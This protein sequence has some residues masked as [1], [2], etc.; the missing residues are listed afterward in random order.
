MPFEI[1][2]EEMGPFAYHRSS[3]TIHVD[4]RKPRSIFVRVAQ[5][6]CPHLYR[7]SNVHEALIYLF[8][9]QKATS[10]SHHLPSTAYTSR[11]A[12]STAL[13]S[14]TASTKARADSEG[15]CVQGGHCRLFLNCVL[16]RCWPSGNSSGARARVLQHFSSIATCSITVLRPNA[17]YSYR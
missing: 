17:R 12:A 2:L 16:L 3:Q 10:I 4:C 14:C 9:G 5:C 6:H 8:L 7:R 11:L 15:E 1:L 13:F